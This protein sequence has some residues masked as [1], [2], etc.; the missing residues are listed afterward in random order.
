MTH[1][2]HQL[3]EGVAPLQARTEPW[4]ED[5]LADSEQCAALVR[6]YGSPVNVL[7]F[8]PVARNARELEDAARAHGV[9]LGV[10]VARKAN[11]ALGLVHAAREAGLGIDVSSLAEL[12]QCLD[13]GVAG[14]R[15]IVTAAVKSPALIELA[16][17][18]RVT[19][20]LDNADELEAVVDVAE[21]VG[22]VARVA[23]RL[24]SSDGDIA[25]T[26]FGLTS[27]AWDQR[28]AAAPAQHIVV[29]G[30]HFH[31]NA[32][33]ARERAVVLREALPWVD[34]LRQAGH[35]VTFVDMGGG[36]PMSYLAH[37]EQ[38]TRFW[39][40]LNE[41]SDGELTWRG[42]RLGLVD[43]HAARPSP[44]MYPYWQS[45]VRG[46]WLSDVLT[47]RGIDGATIAADLTARELELRCEPG[48]SIVDG[49]GMT[50][51]D[52][53]FRKSTSDGIPLVGLAMNRTQV[54]STSVDFLLDPRWVRPASAG[55]PGQPMEG[56]LVGAYCVEEELLLR[57][58][59]RFPHG[60][61]RGDIAA[62]VN[63]AGYLMHILESA[64]HQLPLALNVV[65]TGTG[66]A[67]DQ[68]DA[69]APAVAHRALA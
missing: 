3:C 67:R 32:Y 26:R 64:S 10:C 28:V 34:R 27:Q 38:W 43:P 12:Q 4:M 21:R 18:S 25:A 22:A 33:S 17:R 6:E 69:G 7:D 19:L 44:A 62:F 47:A 30:V 35:P 59:L 49:C 1:D 40:A 31:L 61:A 65:R 46:Q 23:L 5:L 50:L 42:D 45:P 68:I 2:T 14:E 55:E 48:R 11:K 66:W 41:D 57:R 24:A 16:V 37:R 29:E 53:A 20:S 8:S 56:F 13:A 36:I 60:V 39:E 51:A 58:R 52:V 63:T 9:T 15:M 54:R